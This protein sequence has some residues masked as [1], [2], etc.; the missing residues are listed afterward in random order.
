MNPFSKN[1]KVYLINPRFQYSFI[2]FSSAVGFLTLCILYFAILYFFWSFE[3][4]G[5]KLGIPVNHIFFRFIDE[6]R[7]SMNLVFIVA[8]LI[9]LITTSIGALIL[10]HKVAGPLGRLEEHLNKITSKEMIAPVKF[11]NGDFFIEI[12]QSFNTF[13]KNIEQDHPQ[14]AKNEDIAE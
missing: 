8:A 1:R 14:E 5:I 9:G 10:S 12:E 6:E 4:Q 2:V 3:H 13:I 7:N 11:R